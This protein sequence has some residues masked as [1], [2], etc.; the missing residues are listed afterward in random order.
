M[1][2]RQLSRKASV[3]VSK[4]W[5]GTKKRAQRILIFLLEFLLDFCTGGK[6]RQ[7]HSGLTQQTYSALPEPKAT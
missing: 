1:V 5:S 3:K 7:K 2:L 4:T 6:K